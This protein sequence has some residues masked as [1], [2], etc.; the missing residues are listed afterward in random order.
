MEPIF[1]KNSIAFRKWLEK[2]HSKAKELLVGYYKK[3][4]GKP[5]MT[6][7]ESVDQAL[8][9]GWIDGVRRKIDDETYMIRFT[10]RRQGSIWSAVNINK[11]AVLSEAGL[12][13]ASGIAAY[14]KRED[15]KS[16]IY[17][18]EQKPEH[19][20]LPSAFDTVFKKHQQ[21]WA[22]FQTT[23]LSYQQPAIWWVI[24]AKQEATKL[25]RLQSL[26]DDSAAGQRV[27]H[28]RR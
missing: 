2:N 24:S 25:K 18:F 21:A 7:S 4:T 15:K 3:G 12:M 14:E 17:S 10:P 26:I 22:Y 27:K 6:W 20:V 5:S 11:V 9:F 28:L 13:H 19:I 16:K 8:C 23:P 1:F